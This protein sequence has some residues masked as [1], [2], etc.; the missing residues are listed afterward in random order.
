MRPGAVPRDKG[1]NYRRRRVRMQAALFELTT[2]VRGD[3]EVKQSEMTDE[4]YALI[5]EAAEA[6]S[7]AYRLGRMVRGW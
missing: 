1:R 7:Q 2:M 5:E 4:Q 3:F 6:L